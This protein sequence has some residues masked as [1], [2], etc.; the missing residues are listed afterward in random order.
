LARDLETVSKP[1]VSSQAAKKTL[2]VN[3]GLLG[4]VAAPVRS[5]DCQGVLHAKR[6]KLAKKTTP[7]FL[8]SL[9]L[10]A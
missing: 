2:A 6:A 5:R 3:A 8:A 7:C 4:A 9:A 10:F 1:V